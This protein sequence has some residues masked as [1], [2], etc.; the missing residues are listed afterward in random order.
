VLLQ[1]TFDG[2]D[3]SAWR[4]GAGWTLV[5]SEGGQ[6]LQ[7]TGETGAFQYEAGNLFNVAVEARFSTETGT[8][9]ILVRQS[10][11]GAYSVSLA[12]DG[13]VALERSGVVLTTTTAPAVDGAWRTLRLSVLNGALRVAANGAEVITFID[14]A[15]LPPG[16]ITIGATGTMLVDDVTLSVPPG[17]LPTSTP[18]PI[19]TV[20]PTAEVTPNLTEI[21]DS[22]LA[23]TFVVNDTGDGGDNNTGDG[24][25]NNGN[26][27]CTLRAAIMQANATA[28]QDFINFRID[29]DGPHTIT[30]DS[31]LPTIT[32]SVIINGYSEPGSDPAES[33]DDA[34]IRIILNGDDAGSGDNGLVIT[35]SDVTIRGLVINEWGQ[36]GIRIEG[37]GRNARIEGNYIGTNRDAVDS[38]DAV[39]NRFGIVISNADNNVIGGTDIEDRNI[40]SGNR[41]AGVRID[42]ENASGNRVIGNYIGTNDTGNGRLSSRGVGVLID[43][44][45]QN[46]IGGTGGARNIISGNVWGVLVQGDDANNNRIQNN[47]IGPNAAGTASI[48]GQSIGVY[49]V[50][51]DTTNVGGTG[52][53]TGNQISGNTD[54]GVLLNGTGTTGNLVQGNRIGL[55]AD[56][57][58]PL[59]NGEFGVRIANA[60]GNTVGSTNPNGRNIISGHNATN[61]SAGI[62]IDGA[63]AANNVILGNTIGLGSNGTTFVPNATGIDIVSPRNVVG[64]TTAAARNIIRGNTLFGIRLRTASATSNRILGNLIG[65]SEFG[66]RIVDAPSNTIG[67]TVPGSRNVIVNNVTSSADSGAGISITG[68]GSR[69]NLVQ[70]NMIGFNPFSG[71]VGPNYIGVLIQSGAARNTVGGTAPAAFNAIRNNTTD[72]IAIVGDAT[73]DN[74]L[75]GNRVF[76][77]GDL[78]IDLGSDGVD[79]N[80]SLDGDAGP[81][82]RQNAPEVTEVL[83]QSITAT[84]NS[85]PNTSFRVEFYANGQCDASSR[86]E[87]RFRQGAVNVTTGADG[88]ATATLNLPTR[89]PDPSF[90]TALATRVTNGRDTSEYS[91]CVQFIP[92]PVTTAPTM[93]APADS[94]VSRRNVVTFSWSAVPNAYLYEFEIATDADFNTIIVDP[95]PFAGTTYTHTFPIAVQQ[96]FWRVRGLNSQSQGPFEDAALTI[97]GRPQRAPVAI[98]LAD[99]VVTRDNTPTFSWG[100]LPVA[101]LGYRLQI[102]NEPTFADPL[103]RNPSI[104][105]GVTSFTVG[106]ALP[107]GTYYWRMFGVNEYG[108]GPTSPV[109]TF[110]ID[111]VS[112][113]IPTLL[114]PA[115]GELINDRT[116]TVTWEAVDGAVTYR[117]QIARDVNF[118][119]IVVSGRVNTTEFTVPSERI[120][121]VN[122]RFFWRARAI[123]AAG[124][125][126]A[127]SAPRNFRVVP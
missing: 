102:A 58:T 124:N 12:P 115:N 74:S 60:V 96:Y 6:A 36:A 9:Q 80:D 42:G 97:D 113:S 73:L 1:E 55:A 11:A 110:T 127:F 112:P 61:N 7:F 48:G 107:D 116:P 90:I 70:G 92:P 19:V 69:G 94:A 43:D 27:R 47:R 24:Q 45:E 41:D 95:S 118:T 99:G 86:G 54:T 91:N 64:G 40:I 46:T 51:A 29:G 119:Q 78:G 100:A 111:T 121:P 26:G 85:L 77:N 22:G 49:I 44:S 17:E 88:N 10:S 32:E 2:G 59:R 117:I 18:D 108:S 84:L 87:G 103:V 76:D 23:V 8:A 65:G 79:P 53:G 81:N 101:R 28:G 105:A 104:G 98:T 68:I 122:R 123:D 106:N 39:P 35:G 75:L 34:D 52:S 33:G 57:T 13:T 31:P 66:I 15:P 16:T 25:C 14:P 109:R 50:A 72:G 38:G 125:L 20:E 67:G 4:L 114:S 5:A 21:P 37:T 71:Q 63:A 83:P 120:L 93:L 30:P 3:L 126:S 56:G 82:R 62:R 89:L